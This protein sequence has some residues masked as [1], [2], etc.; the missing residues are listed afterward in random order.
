MPVVLPYYYTA[1]AEQLIGR[2]RLNDAM[3]SRWMEKYTII[4]N[5]LFGRTSRGTT[6]AIPRLIY[7]GH[8]LIPDADTPAHL[9]ELIS[10]ISSNV[11]GR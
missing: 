6:S 4:V 5:E 2:E 1:K 10:E 3:Q 9:A 8:I 11:S 7:N